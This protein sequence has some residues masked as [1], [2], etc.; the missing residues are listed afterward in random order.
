MRFYP[1]GSASLNVVTASLSDYSNV[2]GYGLRAFSAVL[3]LSGSIGPTGID[4]TPG[5]L[6]GPYKYSSPICPYDI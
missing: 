6:A 3:A 1:F 4:G 2:A 5:T